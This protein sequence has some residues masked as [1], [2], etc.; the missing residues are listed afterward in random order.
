MLFLQFKLSV[1]SITCMITHKIIYKTLC[2]ALLIQVPL[3]PGPLSTS[4]APISLYAII[5]IPFH[6][7]AKFFQVSTMISFRHIFFQSR[8]SFLPVLPTCASLY[9]LK[10]RS[11]RN[12]PSQF[13]LTLPSL[14]KYLSKVSCVVCSHFCLN[15]IQTI[16]EMCT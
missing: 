5:Q 4:L 2:K 9:S 6:R 3:R 8:T 1:M 7:K 12:L 16:L 10:L 15:I 13:S 14:A 11:T